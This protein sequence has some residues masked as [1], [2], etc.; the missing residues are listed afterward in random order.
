LPRLFIEERCVLGSQYSIKSS[1][2]YDAFKSWAI[3]N[4]HQAPSSTSVAQD[5]KRLFG[6]P[7]H[8]NGVYWMGLALKI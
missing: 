3:E 4:G 1:T 6:Q 7:K 8:S 2:L 5:W